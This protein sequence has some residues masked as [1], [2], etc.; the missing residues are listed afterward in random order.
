MVHFDKLNVLVGPNASGK[1]TFLDVIEVV[2]DCLNFG[3][4][5]AV[6]MRVPQYKD[7][8]YG[9]KGNIIFFSIILD[10]PEHLYY[11]GY[12]LAIEENNSQ[13]VCVLFEELDR[14]P[15][16]G[17]P[18]P[19]EVFPSDTRKGQKLLGKT[20]KG[21]DFF[22]RENSTYQDNFEFGRDKLT[23]ANTPE[24]MTKY[25]TANLVKKFLR[26]G[27][28]YVQL[29]SRAMRLPCPATRPT[30]LEM[31]GSNLARVVGSLIKTNGDK[32]NGKNNT[33]QD[34]LKKW[35]EHLHLAIPDL[36]EIGWGQ[37]EPDN[38]EYIT[39]KYQNGLECPSWLVSDG[40]LRMLALT[41]LA[42]A[43]PAKGIYMIEEPENGVHPK[44]LEVI[45]SALSSIKDSQ[46][47][48]A[49]HSP[50]VVQHAGKDALLCFS[51]D[52]KGT[53]IVKGSEHPVLKEWDGNP[54]LATM[55]ASG[56]LG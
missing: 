12:S 33:S 48:I 24:D 39:L 6:E 9:R 51:H 15:K 13:G 35:T 28:R 52:E 53:K 42:F 44:A 18:I 50:F 21:R 2:K 14:Y 56:I 54:D 30:Y 41:L 8:T 1:S 29:N 55:F 38:A 20:K 7:L 17:K 10:L 26:D 22:Q 19:G 27:I 45:M 23:L 49:T 43:P 36:K 4:K 34:I 32:K 25:P 11:S 46:V 47:F 37:R 16:S 5:Q 40:T 3:P 31:D